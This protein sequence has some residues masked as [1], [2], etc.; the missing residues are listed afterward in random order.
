[1]IGFG[2]GTGPVSG[3]RNHGRPDLLSVSTARLRLS[4]PAVR[5]AGRRS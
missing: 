1:L 3:S 2:H 4:G 5:A